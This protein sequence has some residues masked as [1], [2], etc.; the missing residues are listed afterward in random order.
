MVGVTT[1]E[2][3]IICL[4][5]LLMRLEREEGPQQLAIPE[6]VGSIRSSR[7]TGPREREGDQW[8]EMRNGGSGS[9]YDRVHEG[10]RRWSRSTTYHGQFTCVDGSHVN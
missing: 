9:R 3:V 6:S 2:L 1:R 10:L 4:F 5:P 8:V 7:E